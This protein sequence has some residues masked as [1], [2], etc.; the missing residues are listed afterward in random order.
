[1]FCPGYSRGWIQTEKL[2]E[3]AG[4]GEEWTVLP[5]KVASANE[6]VLIFL[7][8]ISEGASL[9]VLWSVSGCI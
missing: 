4:W 3:G 2:V 6:L 5:R 9:V 8:G 1:V 7:Y